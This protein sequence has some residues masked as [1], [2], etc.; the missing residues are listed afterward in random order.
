M[1]AMLLI[2]IIAVAT[3]LQAAQPNVADASKQIDTLLAQSW[4]KH[5]ITPNP[6]VD[7]ATFLRRAYLTVVGRIPDFG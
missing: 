7:D 3:S 1:K 5:K 2:P 6:L 4:Q